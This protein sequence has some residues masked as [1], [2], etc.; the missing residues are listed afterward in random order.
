MRKDRKVIFIISIVHVAC[1]VFYVLNTNMIVLPLDNMLRRHAEELEK[2]E[3]RVEDLSQTLSLLS[4]IREDIRQSKKTGVNNYP[5]LLMVLGTPL[6]GFL[7]L[8]ITKNKNIEQVRSLNS[9][10]ATPPLH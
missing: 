6:F 5:V 8:F 2:N 7:Y 4:D 1:I 9:E 3:G 10:K